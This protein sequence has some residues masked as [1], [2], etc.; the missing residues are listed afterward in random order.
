M[1]TLKIKICTLDFSKCNVTLYCLPYSMTLARL[2]Y[3]Y[4][5]LQLILLLYIS[6]LYFY[7]LYIYLL[8]T[9]EIAQ[10]IFFLLFKLLIS[11]GKKS[12]FILSVLII[13]YLAS[14]ALAGG[15]FSTESLGKPTL[16]GWNNT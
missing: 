5:I 3:N 11:R 16:D 7:S 9:V 2:F 10:N 1:V 14:P 4:Y 12:S 8:L 15:F 13:M 6:I